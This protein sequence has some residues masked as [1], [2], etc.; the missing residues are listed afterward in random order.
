MKSKRLIAAIL[1]LSLGMSATLMGCK[2][3]NEKNN[4]NKTD[5]VTENGEQAKG[6]VDEEQYLN[7]ILLNE[8]KSLD[9]SKS[10]DL[11]SSQVLAEV[12]E[13]LTRVEQENGKDVIKAAGA[14]SW[15]T[16]EDGTVWTFHLRDYEWS[17]GKKVTAEDYVYGITRTLSKDTGSPYAFLLYPIKNAKA[18]NAG[19]DVLIGV[20]AVDEKTLK[21]T[22]ESPTAFFL[23]LTYF[24]VMH[25]QRKD[26]VEAAGD[27][28]GTEAE[29]MVFCGPFVISEWVHQNKVE[30][31]K[32]PTYWDAE[33]VKLD[34]VTMK[35]ITDESA[36][37]NE[38]SNGSIDA[39]TVT[40]PNWVEE[41]NATGLFDVLKGYDPSTAYTFFNTK[42][43]Y[44]GNKKIRKAFILAGDR[45]G[46]VKALYRN[47]AEP[48]YA[49]APPS[50]QIGGKDFR[51]LANQEPL[52]KLKE[53]NPD[54][55]ALLI[56]GLTEIGENPDPT[57]M[58]ITYLQAGTSARS[59]QFSEFAQQNYKQVLGVEP[60]IDKV[61]WPVFQ[62]RTDE[63]DYQFGGMGWTGDYNDPMTFFDMWASDAGVVPTGWVN[64]EYDNIIAEVGKT[65]DQ[66][67]RLELFKRAEQILLYEDGIISPEVYR[68]RQTYVRKYVSNIMYPLF[69]TVEVKYAYTTGR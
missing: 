60:K 14:E 30:L 59:T 63:L 57:K 5:E 32:N 18:F 67:K 26:I 46:R 49:W 45:E 13:G 35:I 1:A 43:K 22:L 52:L 55:K 47:L 36:R 16:S 39:T 65:V 44:F 64:E 42:D 31:G 40:D 8:P 19:E 4:I 68:Q 21:F 48:A 7:I 50:L 3:T 41:F 15:E 28:Y 38:L 2:N 58:D 10:S 20:E 25:P 23:D 27:K 17:D 33:S 6:E 51:E 62:K 56:E 61:E 37:M 11:Y 54:P 66:E 29:T 53:E 9:A 12:M 69:G 24:K 34:K